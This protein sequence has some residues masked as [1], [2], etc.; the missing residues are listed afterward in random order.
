MAILPLVTIA[1]PRGIVSR[2]LGTRLLRWIGRLSYSLYLWQQLFLPLY[3]EPKSLVQQFPINVIA[4]FLAALLSYHL[5]ERPFI[6]Y[7]RRLVRAGGPRSGAM[8]RIPP[9]LSPP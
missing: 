1:D 5:V 2:L 4:A 9:A 3:D 6:V 7:G 8:M